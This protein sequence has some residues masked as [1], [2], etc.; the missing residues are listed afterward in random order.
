MVTY[1]P[2]AKV[3]FSCDAFGGYGALHGALFDDE[4][5]DIAYYEKE[6]LRYYANIVAKFATPV[7][8]AIKKLSQLK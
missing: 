2:A 4:Y 7:L 8:N 6:S 5:P 1:D 3:L